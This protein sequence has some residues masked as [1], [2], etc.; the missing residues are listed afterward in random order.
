MNREEFEHSLKEFEISIRKRLPSMIN[1]FLANR[2][3]REQETAFNHLVDTLQRQR[4]VLLKDVSKVARQEQK[5]R[6]FNAIYNMDSQLRSMNNKDAHQKHMK[7]RRHRLS[8][9]VIY[10]IGEGPETGDLLNVSEDA[11]L[12]KTSEKISADHEVTMSVSGKIAR[13]KAIWSI[14]D[15]SGSAE[16][17]VKLM[18]TSEDFLKELRKQLKEDN[19]PDA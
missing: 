7:F 1:I 17:G 6:Y 3:N 2:G 13:G 9:P 14:T 12:M 5:I 18:E 11:V 4:K 19:N 10:D 8:A 16:T 15:S